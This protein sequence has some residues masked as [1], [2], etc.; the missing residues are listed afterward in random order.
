M[1]QFKQS[2]G[3][4]LARFQSLIALALMI[5][6]VSLLSDGFFT[7]DNAATLLGQ[8]SVNVCLSVGMTLV[9]V[10][11]MLKAGSVLVPKTRHLGQLRLQ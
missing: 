9:I 6:A 3:K 4:V 7:L 8:I 1:F 5:L 11:L 2:P 10:F